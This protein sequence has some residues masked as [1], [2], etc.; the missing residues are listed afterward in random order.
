MLPS[1]ALNNIHGKPSS[2]TCQSFSLWYPIVPFTITDLRSNQSQVF[3]GRNT[4]FVAG[5]IGTIS[6]KFCPAGT[7]DPRIDNGVQSNIFLPEIQS[8]EGKS[9]GI[10]LG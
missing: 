10:G 8:Y 2:E 4:G 1:L 7:L 6:L 3:W 5:L 9:G